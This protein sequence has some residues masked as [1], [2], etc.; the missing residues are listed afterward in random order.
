MAGSSAPKERYNPMTVRRQ[1]VD[2]TEEQQRARDAFAAGGDL[3]VVA[4]AGTGE[5]STLALMAAAT[6]K[7]GLY[8]AFNRA[9]ADDA[10]RRFSANAACRTAHP[11]A[12]GAVGRVYRDRLDSPRIPSA[13]TARILGITRDLQAGP[14][15]ISQVHQARLVIG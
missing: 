4:G 15:G 13:Q 10:R 12:F 14:T 8:L 5:T 1:S 7:R 9:T 6:R 3:A 2:P 11:L